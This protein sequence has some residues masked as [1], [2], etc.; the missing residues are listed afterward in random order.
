MNDYVNSILHRSTV[1]HGPGANMHFLKSM[2]NK[3]EMLLVESQTYL[4]FINV[5]LIPEWPSQRRKNAFYR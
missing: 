2:Y 3:Y 1:Q 5:L 4:F